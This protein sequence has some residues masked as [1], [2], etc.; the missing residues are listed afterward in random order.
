M[1]QNDAKKLQR[2]KPS[3]LIEDKKSK[4]QKEKKSNES[5]ILYKIMYILYIYQYM[6]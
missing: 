5:G 6:E 1:W 3:M 2:I 4:S